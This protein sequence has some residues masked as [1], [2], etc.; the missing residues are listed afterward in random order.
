MACLVSILIHL[1]HGTLGDIYRPIHSQLSVRI[2]Y[3]IKCSHTK[4]GL[5]GLYPTVVLVLVSQQKS[6]D[7]SV[8]SAVNSDRFSTVEICEELPNASLT[9]AL[10]Y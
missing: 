4:Q 6:L 10:S 3:L 9:P 1:P 2:Y 7:H 5:Q 8:L